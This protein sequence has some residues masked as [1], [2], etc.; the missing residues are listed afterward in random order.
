[1][2]PKR[3]ET[4]QRL[5]WTLISADAFICITFPLY[6][7]IPHI[8]LFASTWLENYRQSRDINLHAVFARVPVSPLLVLGAT[9][10]HLIEERQRMKV[11]L[12]VETGE[13]R[14]VASPPPDRS[15]AAD[16]GRGYRRN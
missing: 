9:H 5:W 10:H 7:P 15:A 14:S 3:L 1:M 13:A 12:I 2:R 6:A 11:G 4:Q 8:P 16:T